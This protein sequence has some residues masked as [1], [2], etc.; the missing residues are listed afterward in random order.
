[1]VLAYLAGKNFVAGPPRLSIAAISVAMLVA[2]LGFGV[3]AVVG[4]LANGRRSVLAGAAFVGLLVNGV[5]LYAAIAAYLV[6][7]DAPQSN[8]RFST[9]WIPDGDGWHVDQHA[10]FAI[11]LPEGW[12]MAP[13]LDE[14]VP[15]VAKCQE[16]AAGDVFRER[17]VIGSD[18]VGLQSDRE[19]FLAEE[20]ERVRQGT[21]GFEEIGCGSKT[22]NGVEWSWIDYR[23]VNERNEPR[24]TSRYI[25][26]RNGRRYH[27][28]CCGHP[29]RALKFEKLFERSI[30]SVRVP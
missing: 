18:R 13:Y 3:W 23:H 12:E 5:F 4:A 9:D 26:V 6:A 17:M 22:I 11:Q 1:M 2:G 15:L 24:V 7:R 8:T 10:L 28:I 27:I 16:R 20:L 21:G 19:A 25:T 14:S 30:A 29:A